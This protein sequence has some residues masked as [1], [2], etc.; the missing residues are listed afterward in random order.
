MVSHLATTNTLVQL[1]VPDALRGRVMSV[2][3]WAVVGMAPLGSLIL[4]SL[5][6]AWDAPRAILL[7]AAVC[8][9]S[10]AVA[11]MALPR[12]RQLE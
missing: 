6:E 8:A 11:W 3:L 12:V 1:L 4:G 5:A 7:G 9:V 10:A 2:Y